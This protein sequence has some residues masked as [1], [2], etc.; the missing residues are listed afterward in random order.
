MYLHSIIQSLKHLRMRNSWLLFNTCYKHPV[1]TSVGKLHWGNSL[2]NGVYQ[3]TRKVFAWLQKIIS[4]VQLITK[5]WT[6]TQATSWNLEVINFLKTHCLV[7]RPEHD[8]RK[9][10]DQID[11]VI[12]EL[13]LWKDIPNVTIN[14]I[15]VNRV[16]NGI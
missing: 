9:S 8:F 6:S 15:Y 12:H 1:M 5:I 14:L 13:Y 16:V 7:Y 2:I 3:V 11:K 10:R 4:G